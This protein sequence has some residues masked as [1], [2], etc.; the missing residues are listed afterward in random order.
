MKA[1]ICVLHSGGD[2]RGV[3]RKGLNN[4][5]LRAFEQNMSTLC[6]DLTLLFVRF[7]LCAYSKQLMP[8]RR[9]RH[10][11]LYVLVLLAPAWLGLAGSRKDP[12]Y[13]VCI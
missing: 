4:D 3:D 7:R 6:S 2:G 11:K 13:V 5:S 10:D 9:R 8:K 1:G 12:E